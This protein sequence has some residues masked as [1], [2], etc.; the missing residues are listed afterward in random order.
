MLRRKAAPTNPKLSGS[1]LTTENII[2]FGTVI[3]V[4][5]ASIFI[6]RA[7]KNPNQMGV[8]E[9]QSMDM[10][11]AA[12]PPGAVP[13]GMA[14]V[15]QRPV[16][17]TVTYTGTV[18]AYNDEVIFARIAGRLTDVPVYPGDRVRRGQV[19]AKLDSAEAS[20]SGARLL[21][22]KFA[23][24]AARHNAETSQQDAR[25]K[26]FQAKASLNAESAAARAV[27]QAKASLTYW[28]SEIKRTENL[29]AQNVVSQQEYDNERS[30][31]EQAVAALAQAQSKAEEAR[32]AAVAAKAASEGMTHHVMH[33]YEESRRAAA[34]EQEARIISSY[35]TIT[36]T[37]DAVVTKRSVSPG[38]LVQPGTE[39]LRVAHMNPVRIQAQVAS[40]DVSRLR[41]GDPVEITVA[42]NSEKIT[43]KLTAIFPA[44]DPTSRTSVAEAV[45]PNPDYH[46]LPGQFVVMK[47][48]VASKDAAPSVPTSAIVRG[49]NRIEVWK[50]TGAQSEARKAAQ[51]VP[52]EI[53]ASNAEFTEIKS[54]LE[55]G[56]EVIYAGQTGLRPGTPV[57]AVEWTDQG[58]A[59]L[60][61]PSQT[62]SARLGENN[63]WTLERKAGMLALTI[64]LEPTPPQ[65][66]TNRLVV[67]V[68]DASGRPVAGA[69]ISAKT[70]M[71]TMSMG[72]P[73]LTLSPSGDRYQSDGNFMSG[74]WEIN[75][76]V[77]SSIDVQQITITA[78]VP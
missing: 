5:I 16:H 60:P 20:E 6:V 68:R 63:K 72:G 8:I 44:A 21:Q 75:L 57:V 73:D 70:S 38:V 31:Y 1:W 71:P 24:E 39:I 43:S 7:F 28:Q 37:D 65:G 14:T 76:S 15:E 47:I 54:G 51:L 30:Q 53:G 78:D 56:D 46:L 55:L 12:P 22:A 3:V 59:T 4:L 36:A 2:G 77:A 34:A 33:Q 69:R 26:Q 32:N 66:G 17:A 11:K 29:L 67:K 61:T 25:E 52:V 41:R 10:S 45:V 19:L 35:R 13:V 27:E 48:V 74:L 40:D 9:S 42:G 49:G 58:P 23:A 18:Q 50:A 62:A 64:S